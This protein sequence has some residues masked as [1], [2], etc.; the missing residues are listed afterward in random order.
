MSFDLRRENWIPWRRKSGTVVWG[1]LNMLTDAISGED[2]IVATAAP[3][4]DFDGALQEFLIGMLTTALWVADEAEW[5]AKWDTPPSPIELQA[6]FDELPDAFDL[7]A[8]QGPRFLQDF[9]PA[10]LAAQAI[11]PIDRLAIDSPGE[12]GVKQNKTLFVKP[13]RFEQLGRPAAAM[14]LITM[15]SYAPAGGQGNRTSMRGGGPLTTIADPRASNSAG[16][17]DEQPLWKALW[18]NAETQAQWSARA[19]ARH[20]E[21]ASAIFPWLAATQISDKNK[22]PVTP[23][24]AHALQAYFGMPRRI[25]LEFSEG[26]HCGLTGV[27]D[28]QCATGFRMRNYG[29]EYVGWK[30]PLSPHYRN[31]D[32]ELLPVHPQPGGLAWRDW[33]D[34]T[35]SRPAGEREPAAAITQANRRAETLGIAAVRLKAFGYDLDKMKARAWVTVNQPLLVVDINNEQENAQ[36]LLLSTTLVEATRL[37]G[38]LLTNAIKDAWFDRGEDAKGEVTVPK[39]QLWQDTESHFFERLQAAFAGKFTLEIVSDARRSFHHPLR[40][41]T[42]RIFDVHCPLGS[43]P[44]TALRRFVSARYSLQR[45]LSGYSKLGDQLFDALNI[46][47]HELP[48]SA[49]KSRAPSKGVQS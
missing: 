47:R 40:N 27:A 8:E 36:L 10:D 45:T 33:P 15:Q 28:A 37:A 20:G 24:R 12:Q 13:G 14:A 4:P 26:G 49:R 38:F 17:A 46:P 5:R 21:S 44:N 11:L 3:R 30:H 32:A 2:P 31:K 1:P 29:V 19:V 18:M 9:V 39:Q 7:D 35:L 43:A 25:R 6:A 16:E 23:Q 34:L 41:I 48:S 22:P 42:L